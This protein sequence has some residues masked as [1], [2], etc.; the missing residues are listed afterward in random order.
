MASHMAVTLDRIRLLTEQKGAAAAL[1]AREREYRTLAEHSPDN[2]ARYDVN[3]RTIYINPTLEKTLG[4]PASKM[5]GTLPAEA[6]FVDAETYH[7]KVV[8]VLQTGINDEMDLILPDVGDGVRYHNVRFV[9]ERGADG[10]VTGVQAIGRDLTEKKRANDI[11]RESEEKYRI[12]IQKIR[13]AVVVHGAD[14]Q[15][16]ISNPMAQELLGLT[17]DQMLGKTAMDSAWHFFLEDGTTM[18]L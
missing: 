4:V 10:A 9:A 8:N 15:I 7:A 1:A 16:L 11:L 2:I 12:L 6:G 3:C 13:A 5:I 18:P 14:T 17:E